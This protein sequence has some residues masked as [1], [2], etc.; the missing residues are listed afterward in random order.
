MTFENNVS[1]TG[2]YDLPKGDYLIT[3]NTTVFKDEKGNFSTTLSYR[4]SSKGYGKEEGK[5][6]DI[7]FVTADGSQLWKSFGTKE[8]PTNHNLH[9]MEEA[10]MTISAKTE[11][12]V[13]WKMNALQAAL[14]TKD[15]PKGQFVK[16][17]VT[18]RIYNAN[19]LLRKNAELKEAIKAGKSADDCMKIVNAKW[20]INEFSVVVVESSKNAAGQHVQTQI[21]ELISSFSWTKE[22]QA[23]QASAPAAAPAAPEVVSEDLPF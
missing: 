8:L 10:E 7:P 18:K 14:R 12:E 16:M 17:R 4:P 22:Y 15:L 13:R 19:N 3:P 21:K 9:F 2:W 20:R 5:W 11:E 1:I 6:G 23:A